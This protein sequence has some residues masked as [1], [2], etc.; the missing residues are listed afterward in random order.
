MT[1]DQKFKKWMEA[2]RSG[3]YKQVQG[4]LMGETPD[5]EIGYCCLGVYNDLFKVGEMQVEVVND[6]D[7]ILQEGPS[8]T[9][10]EIH[11][12]FGEGFCDIGVVAVG[13]EMNDAGNSFLEIA[14]ELEKLWESKT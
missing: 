11:K 12:D 5:G 1:Q 14:D 3:E 10:A 2:L 6:F 13:I 7:G 4:T 8:I 9:Y